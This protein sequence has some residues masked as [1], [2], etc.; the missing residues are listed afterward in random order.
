MINNNQLKFYKKHG[1]L[2][3]QNVFKTSLINKVKKKIFE[4]IKNKKKNYEVYYENKSKNKKIRRIENIIKNNTSFRNL[5]RNRSIKKIFNTLSNKK[6]N[7]FKEKINFKYPNTKG[8][9]PH[10]DGH[11][12]WK[13][14]N[15]NK[16]QK[17]WLKYSNDFINLVIPLEKCTKKNGCL[18][19]SSKLNTSKLGRSFDRITNKVKLY[20]PEIKRGYLNFFS[21]E[22]I[23]MDV[24][25]ILIFN[26]KCAHKSKDN[27]SKTSRTIY[28]ATYYQKNK[29][30][31]KNILNTY[32]RDKKNSIN[33]HLNKS[34]N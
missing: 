15:K 33:P 29:K 21:W 14:K 12:Y 7:L 4:D 5:L 9:K 13:E 8:F 31:K 24:G 10:I 6:Y 26:W 1:Y 3:I 27:N 16:L 20:T 11:F 19:V 23:E 18:E 22:K 34:L 17:G 25:D 28:Y 2:K 32:Y 30:T